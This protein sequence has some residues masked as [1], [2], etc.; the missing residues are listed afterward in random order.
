[1]KKSLLFILF[2]LF[3]LSCEDKKKAVDLKEDSSEEKIIVQDSIEEAKITSER[4]KEKESFVYLTNE[5]VTSFLTEYGKENLEQNV[6]LITNLGT[7]E[8]LLYNDTPLHRANFIY[9][10][11]NGYWD[12]T[13]FHRV[14]DNFIV[15]AGNSDR[16]ETSTMRSKLGKYT[17]PAEIKYGHNR[18]ALAAAK[19]YRA[20]PDD[21]SSSYE[22][23]IVQSSGGAN[24]LNPNY[25]VFGRVN[26]GMEVVDKIAKLETDGSEWPYSN[27]FIEAKIKD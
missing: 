24:H 2:T 15:Q 27:V 8:L 4:E 3:L 21:R 7:I 5:N 20:N 16:K 12:T 6:S 10:L 26:S 19:E 1:M 9:M 25:T 14:V 23:Y 11:K 18:G 22:F 13:F 17:I